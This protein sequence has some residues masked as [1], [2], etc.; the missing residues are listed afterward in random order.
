MSTLT[1][2]IIATSIGSIGSLIGGLILLSRKGLAESVSHILT[3]F[4]AGALLATA[5]FDLLPEALEHAEETGS[6]VDVF[7]WVLIGILSFYLLERGVHWFHFHRSRHGQDAHK[8]P[9]LAL[10]MFGDSMHNFIDGVVIAVT[11]MVN[12]SVG[13]LTALAVAAH[14]IPQEIGDFA[15]M[16][17]E[18]LS[19]KKVLLLNIGS[20]LL[21][22]LGALIAYLV[23]EQIE[24]FLPYALALTTGFFLYIA[25][26]SLI[27][28]IHREEKK[29]Y[30]FWET[31]S[32]LLG[33]VVVW[34]AVT[35]LAYGH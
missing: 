27:P 21:A 10:V 11:F 7:A 26:S 3:S 6:S 1:Q 4:A 34:A 30:A 32:L 9:T 13:V 19:R 23:G 31:F 16:L 29:G 8:R 20:A 24:Q 5:L 2:I 15:V 25:L 22:L 12:P 17:H 33:V 14:E 35:F 28:E 18:G